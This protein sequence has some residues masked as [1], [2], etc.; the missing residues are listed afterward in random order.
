MKITKI[1]LAALFTIGLSSVAFAQ[2][3]PGTPT[4]TPGTTT[5]NTTNTPRTN[6]G[7]MGTTPGTMGTNPGTMGT[8][9]GTMDTRDGTMGTNNGSMPGTRID[10]DNMNSGRQ[11]MKHK[12]KMSRDKGK[13]KTSPKY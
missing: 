11:G 13:M 2:T 7:T 5:P 1:F 4:T 3:T 9:T 12:N 6:T 10:T 8:N